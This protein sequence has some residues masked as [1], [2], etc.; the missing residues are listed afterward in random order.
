FGSGGGPVTE[1]GGSA[2]DGI[3]GDLLAG[4]YLL[5]VSQFNSIFADGPNVTYPPAGAGGDVT[6]TFTTGIFVPPPPPWD[7]LVDGGGDAGADA[8]TAF[9]PSGTGEL[10]RIAGNVEVAGDADLYRINICDLANFSATTFGSTGDTQL[11]LFNTDGTGVVMNDDVPAG[12]PGAGSLLSRIGNSLVTADGDYIIGVARYDNDPLGP[13]GLPIWLDQPFGTERAPDG[14][15]PTGAVT[16]FTGGGGTGTYTLVMTGVCF[17]GGR[18]NVC[19]AAD[20]GSVG[21]V[22]GA[23]N[24]L[25]N[26][27]FV[28]FIDFFF[29]HNALA[30]QGSTGG[31]PGSDGVWDNNDFVVFIDNFFN[32]PASCR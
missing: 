20:L 1:D 24:H 19:G 26:N 25:D 11:F 9:V 31:V 13:G 22:A 32:A 28:V 18:G 8:A 17:S 4:T 5:V 15:E 23:D 7:E 6:V 27:D 21:G 16:S 12:F 29:A 3:H 14:D 2:S 30:D 10:L